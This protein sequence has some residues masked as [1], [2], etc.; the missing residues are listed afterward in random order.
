MA[1]RMYCRYGRPMRKAGG[2]DKHLRNKGKYLFQM[3][4]LMH[5]DETIKKAKTILGHVFANLQKR[6][7]L[8]KK[9]LYVY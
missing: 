3:C 8:Q 9:I 7:E 5:K 2:L 1:I 6:D 4:T